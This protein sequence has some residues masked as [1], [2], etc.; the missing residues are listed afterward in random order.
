MHIDQVRIRVRAEVL[1]VVI[2]QC[3]CDCCPRAES[4]LGPAP[5][6]HGDRLGAISF[7]AHFHVEVKTTRGKGTCP[8]SPS[9]VPENAGHICSKRPPAPLS[10]P[11][12]LS[13]DASHS[14]PP[15]TTT[16][17]TS[18]SLSPTPTGPKSQ[19]ELVPL[20]CDNG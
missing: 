9:R 3:L 19:L 20:L 4:E 13:P 1:T 12:S 17:K 18:L 7:Y 8:G 16:I 14:P 2:S 5:S 15:G 6:A 11:A 10:R